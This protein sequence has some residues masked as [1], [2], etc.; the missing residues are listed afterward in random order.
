[1]MGGSSHIILITTLMTSSAVVM[2]T[3]GV[4]GGLVAVTRVEAGA[5]RWPG[6]GGRRRAA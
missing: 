2:V 4:D 1:M 5:A 3:V 6:W